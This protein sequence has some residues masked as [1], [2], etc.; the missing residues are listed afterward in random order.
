MS[1]PVTGET[2]ERLFSHV[3]E[4]IAVIDDFKAVW[5]NDMML[6]IFGYELDEIIGTSFLDYFHINSI[7][8]AIKAIATTVKTGNFYDVVVRVKTGNG[9]FLPVKGRVSRLQL[10]DK[11]YYTCFVRKVTPFT[12]NPEV[13]LLENEVQHEIMTPMAVIRG[14]VE[15]LLLMCDDKEEKKYLMILMRNVERL[16]SRFEKYWERT[17]PARKDS[18]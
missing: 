11:E 15:L 13:Q 17:N 18:E 1:Q 8:S 10:G 16:Q 9:D 7:P 3:T 4:A 12:N 6:E 5:A 14:Y 2:F